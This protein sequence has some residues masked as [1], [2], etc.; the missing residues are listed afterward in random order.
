MSPG[1]SFV[2]RQANREADYTIEVWLPMPL[3]IRVDLA[4]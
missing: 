4:D 1:M 2:A 3:C